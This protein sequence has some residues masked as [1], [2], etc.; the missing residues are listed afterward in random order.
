MDQE[1]SFVVVPLYDGEYGVGPGHTPAVGRIGAGE[2]RITTPE[3]KIDTLF[4]EGGFM[5]ILGDTVSIL[6]NR[7]VTRD[8]MSLADAQNALTAASAKPQTTPELAAIKA[9]AVDAA[10]YQIHVAQKWGK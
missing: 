6:T 10:R 9:K 8:K 3:E 4:I 1:T 7:A 2:L 5:E